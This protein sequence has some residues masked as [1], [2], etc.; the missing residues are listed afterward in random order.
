MTKDEMNKQIEEKEK[1]LE[2]IKQHFFR[3]V[4]V[5]DHLKKQLGESDKKKE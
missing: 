3:C 1:E 2:A 4:G 5:I